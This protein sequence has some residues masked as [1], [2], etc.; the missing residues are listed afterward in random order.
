MRRSLSLFDPAQD[1]S[2][3]INYVEFRGFMNQLGVRMT[4]SQA[5]AHTSHVLQI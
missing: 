5:G 3:V 2:G 1:G 4:P